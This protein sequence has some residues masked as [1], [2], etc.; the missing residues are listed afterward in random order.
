MISHNCWNLRWKNLSTFALEAEQSSKYIV[1]FTYGAN[2]T[3]DKIIYKLFFDKTFLKWA[4]EFLLDSCY[5][6]LRNV[7]S[8]SL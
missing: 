4:I 8:T 2:W 5:F 3:D 1:V 7:F 6:D